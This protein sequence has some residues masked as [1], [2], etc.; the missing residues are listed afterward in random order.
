MLFRSAAVAEECAAQVL[1]ITGGKAAAPRRK[2][3]GG[4]SLPRVSVSSKEEERTEK[5]RG[6]V[7]AAVLVTHVWPRG[8]IVREKIQWQ[9]LYQNRPQMS[10]VASN[11]V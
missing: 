10:R 2:G 1:G 4:G 5:L 8:S 9:F 6:L 7:W 11:E 3:G